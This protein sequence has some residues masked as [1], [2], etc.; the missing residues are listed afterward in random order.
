MTAE[1]VKLNSFD[2]ATITDAK[3]YDRATSMNFWIA[4]LEENRDYAI[5]YRLWNDQ[6]EPVYESQPATFRTVSAVF[7]AYPPMRVY[8]W[9]TSSR[10]VSIYGP[11]IRNRH[12]KHLRKVYSFRSSV[13]ARAGKTAQ[14]LSLNI[15]SDRLV[16]SLMC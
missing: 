5:R 4:G 11:C 2:D 7:L 6:G 1:F 10:K 15:A 13:V 3:V 16:L 9:Y 8:P 14:F 12:T